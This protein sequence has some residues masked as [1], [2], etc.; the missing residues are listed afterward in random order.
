MHQE[1]SQE[2]GFQLNK[3]RINNRITKQGFYSVGN[4]FFYWF[5]VCLLFVFLFGALF[6]FYSVGNRSHPCPSTRSPP[7]LKP[8][9]PSPNRSG[10][11]FYSKRAGLR[12]A[13][14]PQNPKTPKP[15]MNEKDI[16]SKRLKPYNIRVVA[17]T[18]S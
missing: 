14:K 8:F 16:C 3:K 1:R 11:C 5:F 13:P 12:H 6:V 10:L 15:R 7:A 4:L 9:P 17:V 2:S 18:Q